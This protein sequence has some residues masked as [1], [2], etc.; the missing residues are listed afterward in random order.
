MKRKMLGVQAQLRRMGILAQNETIYDAQHNSFQNRNDG[1]LLLEDDAGARFEGM[2]TLL[3][4]KVTSRI[5]SRVTF[6]KFSVAICCALGSRY[7]Y[8]SKQPLGR[9]E[10][11]SFSSLFNKTKDCLSHTL[12]PMDQNAIFFLRSQLPH[13]VRVLLRVVNMRVALYLLLLTNPFYSTLIRR[14]TWPSITKPLVLRRSTA[15][16]L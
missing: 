13:R 11:G 8:A 14:T 16:R 10:A 3:L 15:T 2:I 5:N 4:S 6:M 7:T 12:I 9:P 1:L